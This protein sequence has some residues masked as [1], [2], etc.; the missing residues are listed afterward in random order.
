MKFRLH[1]TNWAMIGSRR[2]GFHG[3]I[4]VR[5][6]PA[7]VQRAKRLAR[8]QGAPCRIFTEGGR[9]LLAVAHPPGAPRR[10]SGTPSRTGPATAPPS[11]PAGACAST[12]PW[13]TP[14]P[15]PCSAA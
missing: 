8:E 15:E 3:G 4:N 2:G 7:A 1:C 12:R 9:K 5:G 10:P 6:W 14:P 11:P 13:T